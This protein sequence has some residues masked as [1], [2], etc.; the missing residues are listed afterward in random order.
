MKEKDIKAIG[1]FIYEVGVLAKT[2]RSG[3]WFLGTGA[4]SVA[5][6]LLRTAY[7]G[8]VLGSITPKTDRNKIVVLCLI[9]DLGEARTSDL[10][11]VHQRYG[12][13]SETKAIDDIASS[14]P[15]GKDIKKAY[16]E[17]GHRNTL[18]AKL[19]KDAD[20]LEWMATM[21]E[22]EIKG[23]KKA[24]SWA[25]IA[26]KRLKTLNG[27]KVGRVLLTLHPDRW[28]FSEKDRWFVDK[29]EEYK[30]WRK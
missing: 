27:K 16:L 30:K 11:Y 19:A 9:H 24:K 26:Y 18:E 17:F 28:W 29:K 8:Y 1:D 15:F 12:R 23:N 20:N 14:L 6:H 21:R 13:L 4:Q 25:Q 5:E 7:I 3:L 10:N 2:P 22:E